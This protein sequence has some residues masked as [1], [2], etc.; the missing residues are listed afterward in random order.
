MNVN[1]CFVSICI[2]NCIYF[3]IVQVKRCYLFT[4][5]TV[6][7]TK[8]KE[9]KNFIENVLKQSNTF[10][11]TFIQSFYTRILLT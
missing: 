1:K 6:T 11:C 8:V 4:K 5:F 2:C 9:L 7:V 3:G 10:F